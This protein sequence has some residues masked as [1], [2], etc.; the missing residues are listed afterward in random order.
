MDKISN[1]SEIETNKSFWNFVK[2]FIKI[3]GL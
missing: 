3:K 1:F 2:P